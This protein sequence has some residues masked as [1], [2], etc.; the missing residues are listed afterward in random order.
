MT[1]DLPRLLDSGTSEL[2][3]RLLRSAGADAAP[4]HSRKRALAAAS[5]AASTVVVTSG[6]AAA[7]VA[8]STLAIGLKWIGVGF[9]A[10]TVTVGAAS[11]SI[12]E[13]EDAAVKF[14]ERRE[15]AATSE[16]PRTARGGAVLEQPAPDLVIAPPEATG[17]PV[18][19]RSAAAE[20][21]VGTPSH[22]IGRTPLETATPPAT[23]GVPSRS[24]ALEAEAPPHPPAPARSGMPKS[25]AFAAELGLVDQARRAVAANRPD[26]ALSLLNRLESENRNKSFGPEATAIRI[27]A[28]VRSGDRATAARLARDFI[29]RHPNHPLV[30]RVQA[31]VNHPKGG[32]K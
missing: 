27:E 16:I 21:P 10:G 17:D 7:G 19:S 28:L 9:L 32:P 1:R 30:E 31:L 20:R 12:T 18:S 26:V 25:D 3:R 5:L 4:R 8:G 23:T 11:V 29:A 24:F 14:E 22:A 2:G 13:R 6:T 15:P